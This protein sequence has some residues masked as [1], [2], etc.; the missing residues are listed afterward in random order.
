MKFSKKELDK[1]NNLDNLMNDLNTCGDK[2]C[3]NIITSQQLKEEGFKFFK[4]VT[5]KTFLLI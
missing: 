4:N 5:F 2:Y 1:M 3:G